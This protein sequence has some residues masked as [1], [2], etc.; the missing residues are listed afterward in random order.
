MDPKRVGADN[1]A[2]AHITIAEQHTLK[3]RWAWFVADQ[4]MTACNLERI[5]FS[6]VIDGGMTF[7]WRGVGVRRDRHQG[8]HR[9]GLQEGPTCCLHQKARGPPRD[10]S[11]PRYL[12]RQ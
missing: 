9:R 4:K 2:H 11:S 12:Y 7:R 10:H 5:E 1:R 3:V 8:C 6:I